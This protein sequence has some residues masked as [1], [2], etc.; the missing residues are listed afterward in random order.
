[1]GLSD[2]SRESTGIIVTALLLIGLTA[3]GI[4]LSFVSV[5]GVLLGQP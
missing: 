2:E 3:V 1:M 4:A 5:T